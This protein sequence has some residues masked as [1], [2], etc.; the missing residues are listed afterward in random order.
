MLVLLVRLMRAGPSRVSALVPWWHWL[1]DGLEFFV[2]DGPA[3][4][5][6]VRRGEH[7]IVTPGGAQEA[8]R[9]WDDSY[10]VHW[11]EHVGY[12]RL[13][14]KYGLPI[15]PVGAAGADGTYIGLNDGPAFGRALGILAG[16]IGHLVARAL[17]DEGVPAHFARAA[18]QTRLSVTLFESGARRDG[19]TRDG[20]LRVHR[21]VTASVQVLIDHARERVRNKEVSR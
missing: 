3:L 16:D 4:A 8:C 11:G 15:V 12:V 10:R 2:G 18:G 13:A 9:R 17:E 14:V 7:L 21:R 20:L 5:A 19:E 1:L 6:A